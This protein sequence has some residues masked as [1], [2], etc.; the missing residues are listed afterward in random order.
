MSTVQVISTLGIGLLA[1]A[2]HAL[3]G[4]DHMAGVAPLA[5]RSG[6][7]A[8]RVGIG[9]GLG[10]ASGA[11]LAAVAALLL[12][13]SV[14]QFE[15]TVAPVSETIVGVLLCV[16]GVL[17]LRR[18]LRKHEHAH[19]SAGRSRMSAFGLGLFH[20]AA[21]LSHLFAVLPALALP[22]SVLPA[23][24]LSGYGVG[25]LIAIVAFASALGRLA[26]RE[27]ARSRRW[28]LGAASA[29]S[30]AVGI[31]WIVHPL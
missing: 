28:W 21:G 1:G 3:S 13:E 19:E 16:L 8:W 15:S 27:H 22:G 17:G 10:H 5:A 6:P 4:P 24:Y 29:T 26:G 23:A 30:L 11:T 18:A 14:P 2:H 12:R 25:S 20:G 31:L 9:W 7:G